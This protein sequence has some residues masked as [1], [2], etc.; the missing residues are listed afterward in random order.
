MIADKATS[1]HQSYRL[2]GCT[3]CHL[4]PATAHQL[5]HPPC[6]AQLCWDISCQ[7][8]AIPPAKLPV[9]RR[10]HMPG[11]RLGRGL[12]LVLTARFACEGETKKQLIIFFRLLYVYKRYIAR[13]RIREKYLK[14]QRYFLL[15]WLII[16]ITLILIYHYNSIIYLAFCKS[17]VISKGSIF[18]Q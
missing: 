13:R 14:I 9:L 7:L 1:G 11:L 2:S 5:S 15:Q 6:Y 16:N 10:A 12:V 18:Q 3:A 4:P 8:V 17:I